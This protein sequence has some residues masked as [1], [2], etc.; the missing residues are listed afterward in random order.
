MMRNA[1]VLR[2][3]SSPL[4]M[5]RFADFFIRV[6]GGNRPVPGFYFGIKGHLAGFERLTCRH[7]NN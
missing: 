3:T 1:L 2:P 5:V 4:L 6:L 7:V